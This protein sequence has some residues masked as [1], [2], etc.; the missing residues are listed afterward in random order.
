[1][2]QRESALGIALVLPAVLAILGLIAYPVIYNIDLSFHEVSLNPQRP[3]EFIG[4]DNFIKLF[5]DKEF[6]LVLGVTILFV[7]VSVTLSTTMGLL[8]ALLMNRKFRFRGVA[9]SLILLPYVTPMI[10]LVY[11]WIYMFNPIYGVV[12]YGL[13][14]VLHLFDSAPAWFDNLGFSFWLVIL[15]D[16]WRVFPY[17]F[18]MILASLQS[19]DQTLYEAADVDGAGWF[20]KFRY[21]TL[22]EIMPAIMSVATLR[23]IWNF[24]KFDDVY[25]LTQQLPLVGVYLYKTA[26]ASN[27]YGLAAAI[28]V[29]LFFVVMLL[30]FLMRK[31][32]FRKNEA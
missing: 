12:N 32:L 7:I 5:T 4:L 9:R 30:V 26:F 11:I 21:I 16:T 6:Y 15:F 25:L 28:T 23:I 17:A 8:V 24:Y 3:N 27:D 29:V 19:V 2:S 20:V 31:V 10:S 18:M 13:V 14:D 22:P 1:M